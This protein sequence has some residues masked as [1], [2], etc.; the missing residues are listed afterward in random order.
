MSSKILYVTYLWSS[1]EDII[2]NGATTD[3]KGMPAFTKII[4]ELIRRNY[5]IDCIFYIDKRL[6]SKR[7]RINHAIYK[8]LNVIDI[9]V[10]KHKSGIIKLFFRVIDY[11]KIRNSVGKA[12]HMNSY[13]FV[14]GH[15][16]ISDAA[17]WASEK[18]KVPFGQR[19]YGDIFW[20]LYQQ[21]GLI[22]AILSDF[23]RY[24]T[25]RKRKEFLLITDD[26]TQGDKTYKLIGGNCPRYQM[27]F[28]LNGIDRP[29]ISE[30]TFPY[31]FENSD[32]NI[33]RHIPYLLYIARITR[34]KG[35]D[36]AVDVLFYLKKRGLHVNLLLAGQLDD[37]TYY[38]E[39]MTKASKKGVKDQIKYLGAISKNDIY[40]LSKL[41]VAALS[42][43]DIS[44]LGNVFHE[45]LSYGTIII[46]KN[47][48]TL[49][50]FITNG[51]NGFLVDEMVSA[52][53]IVEVLI[54]DDDLVNNIRENALKTS[55]ERMM[56]WDIRTEKE[57][58]LI[59]SAINSYGT[60][61]KYN[62][63]FTIEIN[64]SS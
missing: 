13:D 27:Y 39:I 31:V 48:G 38:D 45:L 58:K 8:K 43:Y 28:W 25:Y 56:T 46:S 1:F 22:Y 10:L 20:N 7:L 55:L 61:Y 57:I 30:V 59:E 54:N 12:M 18:Y 26:G 17:R 36:N 5:N 29:L 37:V 62:S 35:Q 32:I 42:F 19:V 60:S 49:D 11:F 44:N 34:W 14:Y 16:M 47:D 21:K 50:R 53:D 51:E 4:D 15:G 40:K 6:N 24:Y 23:T 52:A 9:I 3:P 41:S 33:T 63:S 64:R 2:L